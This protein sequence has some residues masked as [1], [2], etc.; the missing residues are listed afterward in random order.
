MKLLGALLVL[1]T[2]AVLGLFLWPMLQPEAVQGP[3]PAE[4]T[5]YSRGAIVV[6]GPASTT[7]AAPLAAGSVVAPPG[8]QAVQA[9]RPGPPPADPLPAGPLCDRQLD[10]KSARPLALPPHRVVRARVGAT[11]GPSWTWISLW[12][13]WCKPCKE[14]MPVLAAWARQ[15]RESGHP[16]HVL[17]LSVDDDERELQRF[18]KGEGQSVEG[19]FRWIADENVRSAWYAKLGLEDPPTLPVQLV[20][21]TNDRLRCLRVGSISRPDLDEAAAKLG[22]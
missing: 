10:E 11:T 19:E 1:A 7:P 9:D 14:E 15:Q 17:F 4:T 5:S 20:L 18:M 13:A 12:A 6:T 2:L 16:I 3:E 8:V 21:D 22:F